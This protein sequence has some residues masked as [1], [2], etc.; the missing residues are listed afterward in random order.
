MFA[1]PLREA[2]DSAVMRRLHRVLVGLRGLIIR[3][4]QL[5][6]SRPER[7]AATVVRPGYDQIAE[8]GSRLAG[9][10]AT[11]IP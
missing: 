8:R 9:V 5:L 11:T 2:S 4:R 6:P 10:V 7:P 3:R 1:S